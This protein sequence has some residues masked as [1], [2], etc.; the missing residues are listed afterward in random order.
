[1]YG[2]QGHKDGR[3]GV[4]EL[5][6]KPERLRSRVRASVKVSGLVAGFAEERSGVTG[7]LTGLW[8]L[9]FV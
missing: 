6:P 7:H 8:L 5:D 1:M 4:A 9:L 3:K 2:L